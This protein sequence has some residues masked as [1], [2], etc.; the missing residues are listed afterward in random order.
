MNNKLSARRSSSWLSQVVSWTV[1]FLTQA[2]DDD[3][4]YYGNLSLGQDDELGE[5]TAKLQTLLAQLHDAPQ[6]TTDQV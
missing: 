4:G 6:P 1:A 3:L 5:T 2:D